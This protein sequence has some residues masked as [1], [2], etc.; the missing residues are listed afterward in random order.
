MIVVPV[1]NE[2]DFKEVLKKIK[3]AEK[4]SPWIHFDVADGKFTAHKTW[5][6]FK[7]LKNLKANVEIHLMAESPETI[8]KDWIEAGVKRIIFHLESMP[9]NLK[10][11]NIEMGLAVNPETPAKDLTPNLDKIKFVQILAVAPGV[12][13]QKFQPM[14]LEKIKF[15]KKNYPDVMIEVDGGIN[16]ENVKSIKEAGADIIAVGSSIFKSPNPQKVFEEFSKI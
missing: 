7:D 11:R 3:I 4:F 5:N 8:I 9:A 13:G 16:L 12:G 14:V 1:I 15:L 6:N 10:M 2:S